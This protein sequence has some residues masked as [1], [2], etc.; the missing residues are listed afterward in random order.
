[1]MKYYNEKCATL[2]YLHKIAC[3]EVVAFVAQVKR[4]EPLE[5]TMIQAE[6]NVSILANRVGQV[7]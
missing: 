7:A 5:E 4:V 6:S 1:M 2:P 3:G